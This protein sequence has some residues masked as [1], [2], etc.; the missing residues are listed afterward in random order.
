MAAMGVGR[1]AVACGDRRL[2]GMAHRGG[3]LEAVLARD[4]PRSGWRL[5]STGWVPT[6]AMWWA[7]CGPWVAACSERFETFFFCKNGFE[8]SFDIGGV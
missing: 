8:K 4:Q 3:I 1:W 6:S 5:V 7:G 2:G